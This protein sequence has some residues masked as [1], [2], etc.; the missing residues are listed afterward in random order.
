MNISTYS[1]PLKTNKNNSKVTFGYLFSEKISPMK[2]EYIKRDINKKLTA[3]NFSPKVINRVTTSLDCNNHLAIQILANDYCSHSRHFLLASC[4]TNEDNRTL[5]EQ[6]AQYRDYDAFIEISKSK[7][8]CTD[9]IKDMR[10]INTKEYH[11]TWTEI[12]QITEKDIN[13]LAFQL[14]TE[15]G[16]KEAE[17][18]SIIRGVDAENIQ[19][20]KAAINDK[21]Y[22]NEIIITLSDIENSKLIILA[23]KYRDYDAIP[24]ILNGKIYDEQEIHARNG[25]KQKTTNNTQQQFQDYS[26]K[27]NSYNYQNSLFN[28]EQAKQ[29]KGWTKE[30]FVSHIDSVLTNKSFKIGDLKDTEIRNLG[31]LLCTTPEMITKMDKKEHR[32]LS[33]LYHPDKN[34]N[35]KNAEICFKLVQILYENS[36][37]KDR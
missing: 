20:L 26:Y 28:K 5:I 30:Q 29:P 6:A 15:K 9:Q 23:L 27:Q 18:K 34:P 1:P 14:R 7:I 22:N 4:I 32:K 36:P 19:A 10:N 25:N 12:P 16:Y 13:N 24:E 8:F 33:I 3:R 11:P 31:K 35:D 17:I 21:N 37:S 2:L